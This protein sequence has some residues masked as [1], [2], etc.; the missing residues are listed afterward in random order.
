MITLNETLEINRPLP[1]VFD[2]V[3]N[4]ENVQK[5]QPAV[6]EVKRITEGPIRVGTQFAEVANMMGKRV[7]TTCEITEHELN[8]R[9]S[10]KGRSDGPLEY[11]S[12]YTFESMGS[13]TRIHITGIFRAKGFWRLLEPLMRREVEKESKQELQGMKKFIES[14]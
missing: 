3:A 14:R 6:I 9:F 13:G 8:K 7:R 11:E 12:T 5:W 10:F 1:E 4:V 2:Y